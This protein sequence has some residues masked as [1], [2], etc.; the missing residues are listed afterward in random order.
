[1]PLAAFGAA[2]DEAAFAILAARAMEISRRPLTTR[3]SIPLVWT[4][5]GCA[6]RVRLPKAVQAQWQGEQPRIEAAAAAA[7]ARAALDPDGFAAAREAAA[8]YLP[9]PRRAPPTLRRK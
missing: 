7:V 1:V 9:P 3:A 8:G 2:R 6:D 4:D 5:V